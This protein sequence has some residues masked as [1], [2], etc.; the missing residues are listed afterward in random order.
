MPLVA[1]LMLGTA[2]LI[3]SLAGLVWS[4]RRRA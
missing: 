4:I 1:Q 2:A 3:T